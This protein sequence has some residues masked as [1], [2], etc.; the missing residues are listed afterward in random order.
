M[1]EWNTETE[2]EFR[3]YFPIPEQTKWVVQRVE[4]RAHD[5]LYRFLGGLF[6]LG[7]LVSFW[8]LFFTHV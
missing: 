6:L 7:A 8:W 3:E 4:K 2:R 5:R 1:I